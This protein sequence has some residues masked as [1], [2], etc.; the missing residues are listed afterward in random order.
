MPNVFSEAEEHAIQ[1]DELAGGPSNPLP[2]HPR[3]N[4]TINHSRAGL[5]F[6]ASAIGLT[7]ILAAI[8]G[9]WLV[10]S[11]RR[12]NRQVARLNRQA[13]Q[14]NRRI[15]AAEHQATVSA[16][17]ASQAAA[18][19]RAVAAERQ[20]TKAPNATPAAEA[21]ADVQKPA[22]QA[23]PARDTKAS[24]AQ[25]S[26]AAPSSQEADQLEKV[27]HSLAQIGETRRT[28]AGLV[29][30]LGEKS[31]RFDSGKSEIAPK[32]HAMLNRIAA[33]LKPLKGYSVSV[34]A[35]T[36]DSGTRESNLT[37]SA[38]RARA[39]RDALV[40]AGMAPSLIS[41]KGFGNSKPRVRGASATARATNRRVE[42]AIIKSTSATP[43]PAKL[44]NVAARSPQPA[45]R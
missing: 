23:E 18:D 30:T 39:V 8:S 38:R 16:Q 41:T 21:T 7:L 42:I 40:K 31:L 32:Y 12:L 37:L 33:T 27:Q 17:Q 43:A 20:Q 36:D 45:N 29:M 24:A 25:S 5:V 1:N 34:Y 28:S 26:P 44:S 14:F 22:P 15:D 6:G 10:R 9:F 13:E 2:P 4:P 3:E 35:Y 19:A 11:V